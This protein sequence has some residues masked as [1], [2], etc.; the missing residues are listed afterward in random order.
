MLH[1]FFLHYMYLI[2][3]TSHTITHFIL[4]CKL[5]YN[6]NFWYHCPIMDTPQL[7]KLIILIVLLLLSAFFSSAETAFT[8][9][10][11]VRLL[12][13]KEEGNKRAALV[14][15]ILEKPGKMLS[16]IL[17]GNN[18]VNISASA[19]STVLASE[20]FGSMAVGIATG[21]LTLFVLLFGEIL[22]KTLAL[23]NNEKYALGYAPFIRALSVILTPLIFLIDKLSNGIL[24]LLGVDP[25]QKVIRIT[26]SELLGYVDVSHQDGVIET[27]EREM[28]HNMFE[29]SDAVARDIMIPRV[30]MIMADIHDSYDDIKALFKEHMYTR[31]PIYKDEPDNIVG[32][33]NIKDFLFLEDPEHFHINKIMREPYY[34]Y[35]S[36][37]IADLL[38]EMRQKN[39]SVCIVLNEYGTAEGMISIEDM[40]EEIIGQIRDEY[41]ADEAELIKPLSDREYLVDGTINLDDINEQLGTSYESEDYDSISGIIIEQLDDRLPSEGETVTLPDGTVLKVEKLDKQR[42][43]TVRLTLPEKK[44][45]EDSEDEEV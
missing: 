21:I 27:E 14:L 24:R 39:H 20:L 41:D 42:I 4:L 8:T 16:T 22:P 23:R 19:I 31:L 1:Y 6:G 11:K 10:K 7:I 33:I 38:N 18:V 13:L 12:L 45:T 43:E 17:I 32:I 26:E 40:V 37:K 2:F 5:A 29:F 36:K 44:N 28:I 25:N 30:N 15:K 3:S 9:V 34:T 35:E